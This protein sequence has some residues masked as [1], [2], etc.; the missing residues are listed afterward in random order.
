MTA[1]AAALETAVGR[2][3]RAARSWPTAPPLRDALPDAP[4]PVLDLDTI[5]A[6]LSAAAQRAVGGGPAGFLLFSL[7]SFF[8]FLS[9]SPSFSSLFSFVPSFFFPFF[10]FFSP[11]LSF[12]SLSFL[13][14]FSLC[15]CGDEF[16]VQTSSRFRCFVA[17]ATFGKPLR[18]FPGSCSS[19]A[20]RWTP[21][22]SCA[23]CWRAA[24]RQVRR[25]RAGVVEPDH[26]AARGLR[27]HVVVDQRRACARH[28]RDADADEA[29]CGSRCR[30]IATSRRYLPQPATMPKLGAF[31]ITLP[32]T[33]VS[34]S[35]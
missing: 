29:R 33:E 34:A 7:S 27:D 12:S 10:F 2:A 19:A 23:Y 26:R 32:V 4:P 30:M 5:Q 1:V 20:P 24:G 16:T 11:L 21:T 8:S 28:H 22:I 6:A 35:T 13:L 9:F 14:F 3:G 15:C 31:S 18:T 25:D 17:H